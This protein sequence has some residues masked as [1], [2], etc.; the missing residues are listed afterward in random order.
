MKSLCFDPQNKII[1]N[2]DDF[3]WCCERD[4]GILEL[5][6]KGCITS[7][8]VLIN[9]PNAINALKEAKRIGLP[10]GLH[11]NLTEGM[12]VKQKIDNNT[13][14]KQAVFKVKEDDVEC[15]QAVFHDKFELPELI[16]Q[17]KI[18]KEH[19]FKE[20]HAQVIITI[21]REKIT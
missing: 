6:E 20:I 4:K 1:I 8:T 19:V 13:L 2:A 17:G 15:L 3:G 18:E 10:V 5:F 11:L 7:T 12:P 9:G 21:L 14:T 16:K